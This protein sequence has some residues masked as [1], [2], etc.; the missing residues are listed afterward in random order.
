MPLADVSLND[1]YD[2]SKS[3][4]F[5]TGSHAIVRLTLMQKAR[6]VSSGEIA[7]MANV[8]PAMAPNPMCPNESTPVLPT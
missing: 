5:L 7:K 3:R 1:K 4:I 6:G 8:Y 2:L